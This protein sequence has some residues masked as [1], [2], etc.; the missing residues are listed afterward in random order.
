MLARA[1]SLAWCRWPARRSFLHGR[2]GDQATVVR[3][4]TERLQIVISEDPSISG[5]LTALAIRSLTR[6]L[7]RAGFTCKR[8][9]R[10][11]EAQRGWRPP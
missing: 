2:D 1:R 9:R 11:Y 10:V 8:G 5:T 7:M 6:R 4:T 3:L